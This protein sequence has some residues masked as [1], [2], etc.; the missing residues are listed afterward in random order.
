MKERI[1]VVDDDAAMRN[2]LEDFLRG[3]N[4]EV[5][6]YGLATLALE[7][8]G[9]ARASEPDLIL[10]DLRMPGMDGMAF[11]KSVK[12]MLPDVPVILATAFGSIDSA[13][14]A[15]RQGAYDYTV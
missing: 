5:Q 8:L 9:S 14:Q 10:T 1:I 13:I 6:S 7:A 3:E 11:L 4:Y 2:L 15:I 12:A